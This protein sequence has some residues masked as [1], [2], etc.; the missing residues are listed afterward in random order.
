MGAEMIANVPVERVAAIA[1]T[2][3]DQAAQVWELLHADALGLGGA[4]LLW[5]QGR[6]VAAR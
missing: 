1:A 5:T 6:P 2:N 4:N 3:P